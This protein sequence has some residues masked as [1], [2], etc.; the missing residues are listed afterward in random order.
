MIDMLVLL[1]F[2]QNIYLYACR[3]VHMR[4]CTCTVYVCTCV[5]SLSVDSQRAIELNPHNATCRHLLGQWYKLINNNTIPNCML[6]VYL[7]YDYMCSVQC[8]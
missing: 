8:V 5:L 3:H 6:S 7:Y 1:G 2:V 4:I